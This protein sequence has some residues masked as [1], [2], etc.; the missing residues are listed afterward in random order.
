M[1][2]LMTRA[3]LANLAD[4]GA[5]RAVSD[6]IDA[7]NEE[8]VGDLVRQ[9]RSP[10]SSTVDRDALVPAREA[11]REWSG[12]KADIDAK[13]PT[14]DFLGPPALEFSPG[15]GDVFYQ[16]F[17]SGSQYWTQSFRAHE[18]PG[19]IRDKYD[20]MGSENCYLGYPT[21]DELPNGQQRYGNFRAWCS[22]PDLAE[23]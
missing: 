22:H 21:S 4:H 17:Q 1:T 2:D 3:T 18:V 23:E 10:T 11:I 13:R 14:L 20:Q 19:A 16:R 12:A 5:L 6:K 15:A 7:V 8:S 9:L